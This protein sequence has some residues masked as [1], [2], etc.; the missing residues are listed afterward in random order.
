MTTNANLEEKME[1][2][3]FR[4]D[5]YY[6]IA[7]VKLEVPPLA[8]RKEDIRPLVMR[9]LEGLCKKE[10]MDRVPGV[11]ERAWD[12]LVRYPWK[13]N[14]RELINCVTNAFVL[15]KGDEALD[16]ADFFSPN[17]RGESTASAATPT[18]ATSTI[19]SCDLE[20]TLDE[21]IAI[22][23]EQVIRARLKQFGGKVAM[24]ARTL[25]KSNSAIYDKMKRLGIETPGKA[26][27]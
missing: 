14:V 8:K 6:R 13:G 2:G 21:I 22:V 5:L 26:R 12:T 27:G 7:V 1:K 24:A 19:G 3:M 9:T 25:G 20:G 23:E 11:T 17:E 10:N 15:R 4:K 16:V 18:H